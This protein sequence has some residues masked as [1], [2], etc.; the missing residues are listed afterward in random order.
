MYAHTVQPF[1]QSLQLHV[2]RAANADHFFC[3]IQ[4]EL[5][6]GYCSGAGMNPE[7][8]RQSS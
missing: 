8:L 4:L 6:V 5:V 3:G 1:F 7:S 2:G